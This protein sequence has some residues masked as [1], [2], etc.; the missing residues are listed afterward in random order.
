MQSSD[1][2]CPHKRKIYEHNPHLS[3][4]VAE[5][6][7]FE[8]HTA[9]VEFLM[10]LHESATTLEK[11]IIDNCRSHYLGSPKELLYRNSSKYQSAR[12]RAMELAS[13]FPQLKFEIS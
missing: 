11:V 13:I 2:S 8:W 10:D 6:V 5:F 7:G 9:D 12:T 4:K 1:L 3:L